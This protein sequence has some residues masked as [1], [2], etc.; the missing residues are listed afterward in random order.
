MYLHSRNTGGDFIKI[1]KENRSRFSTGVVHSYT[2]CVEE[3]KEII[4]LDLYVGVNGCSFKT[5]EN[6][7]V[8]KHIPLD[9]IMIETDSPYCEIRNTHAGSKLVKTKTI[10]VKKEKFKMG[11]KVKSRNEPSNII[12]VAEVLSAVF[13]KPIEEIAEIS[14]QNSLRCFGL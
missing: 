9:K 12:Q 3:L 10:D 4:S 7:E 5:E 8:L 1:V 13:N 6:L 2:G 14:Y 11:S